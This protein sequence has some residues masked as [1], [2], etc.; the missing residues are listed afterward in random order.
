MKLSRGPRASANR[1]RSPAPR[2]RVGVRRTAAEVG[3]GRGPRKRSW[4][5]LAGTG[6]VGCCLRAESGR[7]S[8]D[9][10]GRLPGRP[11]S[12]PSPSQSP[13]NPVPL[14]FGDSGG[15]PPFSSSGQGRRALG[16]DALFPFFP[17]PLSRAGVRGGQRVGERWRWVRV[18][19]AP[20]SE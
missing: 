16:S 13:P 20:R 12:L 6:A 8:S 7:E 9:C 14:L 10:G 5:G 17:T 1:T 4:H 19:L 15:R 2:V 3:R 11:R 18:S